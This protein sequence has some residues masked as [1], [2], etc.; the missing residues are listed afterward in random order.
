MAGSLVVV[1]V[2][3]EA[4]KCPRG[5]EWKQFG[6]RNWSMAVPALIAGLVT[7]MFIYATLTSP[8]SLAHLEAYRPVFSWH[9]FTLTNAHFI[10]ELLY[11]SASRIGRAVLVAWPVIFL[12]AFW[13]RDRLLQLMAFWVVITPLP[14]AFIPARGGAMLYIVLFGWAMIV[15]RMLEEVIGLVGRVLRLSAP[16]TAML[17]TLAAAAAAVA[18]AVFTHWQNQRFDQTRFLLSS[19]QK[20]LHVIQAL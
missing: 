15:A 11:D 14:L 6:L 4:L 9:R 2:D 12:Y 13:R 5:K 7:A 1:V 19:G 18:L 3:Y 10:N 17:R 20:S 8:Y 16:R